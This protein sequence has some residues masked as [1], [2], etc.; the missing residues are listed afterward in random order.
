MVRQIHKVDFKR[1]FTFLKGSLLFDLYR[2]SVI[3]ELPDH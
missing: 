1:A 2:T 3:N